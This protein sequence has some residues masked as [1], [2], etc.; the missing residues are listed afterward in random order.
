[1]SRR[2]TSPDL[3]GEDIFLTP[4]L[5]EPGYAKACGAS[6][7]KEFTNLKRKSCISVSS[8]FRARQF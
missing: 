4:P 6:R 3:P 5:I 7:R 1:M 2:N 8:G